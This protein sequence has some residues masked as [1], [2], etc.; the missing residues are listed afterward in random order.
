M[1]A[2]LAHSRQ[3]TD[4]GTAFLV[5]SGLEL[6]L[7]YPALV[8]LWRFAEEVLGLVGSPATAYES[9]IEDFVSALHRFGKSTLTLELFSETIRR[10]WSQNRK[11]AIDAQTDALTGL[12]NRRS[13]FAGMSA[14][15]R[16]AQRNRATVAVL[17]IDVDNF[18]R[19][20]DQRGH[21]R[22]DEVLKRVARAIRQVVRRSDVVARF[23]GEEFLIFLPDVAPALLHEIAEKIRSGVTD[24]G[25]EVEGVTVSVGAA[26]GLLEGD[27][28]IALDQLIGQADGCLY[29]AKAKGKNVIMIAP[30]A[31]DLGEI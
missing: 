1:N 30:S 8:E 19:V 3:A 18:K 20:N 13:L 5:A 15:G 24:L 4:A 22:G 11:L 6:Y 23:G 7:L 27:V 2:L 10:L 26:S 14:L 17:I 31:A 12:T 28:D 29:A 25:D 16:L 9:H 21:Q